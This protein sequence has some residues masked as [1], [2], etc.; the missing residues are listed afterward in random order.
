M[1]KT[2]IS[3]ACVAA[4]G[5][6]VPAPSFAQAKTSAEPASVRRPYRGIFGGGGDPSTPQSLIFS[7]S[8]Y[9]AYDDNIVAGLTDRRIRDPFLQQSGPYQGVD[10]GLEYNFEKRTNRFSIATAAGAMGRYT[11][12]ERG[13]DTIPYGHVDLQMDWHMTRSTVLSS[14]QSTAYASRYNFAFMPHADEVT[15]QDVAFMTQPDFDLFGLRALRS[16]SSLIVT[17]QLWS[18]RMSLSGGYIYRD[19]NVMGDSEPGSRFHDYQTQ[20]G[21]LRFN[22]SK[23]VTPHAELQLG[24]GVRVSD[25]RSGAGEPRVMQTVNAGVNYSRALSFSRR[26]SLSFSTGSVILDGE[27]LEDGTTDSRPRFRFV[28][29]ASLVREMGRTWT[30]QL[31]YARALRA[32]DGFGVLYFTDV[33]TADLNG[34]I[35][36]RLSW[37]SSA[38]WARSTLDRAGNNGHRGRSVTSQATYALNGTFAL[39]ARYV[40]YK[41]RYDEDIPLDP[42]LPSALDR[43]GIRVGLTTSVPLIR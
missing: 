19:V 29:N 10:A 36:R 12:S 25:R 43:Q 26:T 13:S 18:K 4:I 40:Y 27:R 9:G 42:R 14:H 41:Y 20:S 31:S 28:G 6:A 5:L 11:H 32:R 17:Q 15:D 24:Y 39:F 2:W 30:A 22:Y 16:M 8:A 21:L 3:A 35:T 7:G 33:G 1:L 37:T 34:L 38:S 23:P